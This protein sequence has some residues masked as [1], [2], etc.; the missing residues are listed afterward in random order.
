[1]VDVA[2]PATTVRYTANW[3]ASFEGWLPAPQF[4]TK[5]LPRRLPGSMTSTWRVS[6]Y[7]PVR[8]SWAEPYHEDIGPG[9]LDVEHG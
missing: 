5:G 6:G 8:P 9:T 1:M 3:R 2:T 4:L 7:S